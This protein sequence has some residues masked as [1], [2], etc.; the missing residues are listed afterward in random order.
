VKIVSRKECG[1][2]AWDGVVMSSPDGWVW[3]LWKWQE[4]ILAVPRWQLAE[5][6]FAVTDGSRPLAVVPLQWSGDRRV[7]GCSGWGFTAPAL[8][9]DLSGSERR[10]TLDV[11]FAEMDRIARRGSAT[12]IDL[13]LS[14]VSATAMAVRDQNP[15]I[16]FG[17]AGTTGQ[18]RALDLS[19]SEDE[20]LADCSRDTRQQLRKARDR[21][22]TSRAVAWPE[23]LDD[24]YRLHTETYERT[25][26]Q[27]HPRE[28]FSGIAHA[29]GHDGHSVLSA[30]FDRDGRVL[31]FHNTARLA[32]GA[33][34]HTGCSTA[35]ALDCGAN[36]VA[37]WSAVLGAKAAGVRWYE[38]GEV[39]PSVSSG[40]QRGLTTFKSKFGGQ[41]LSI[42]RATRAIEP[43]PAAT[44]PIG[45]LL[46]WRSRH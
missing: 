30:A 21:G 46:R 4:L 39:F 14:P 15:F 27:P 20:L 36:Y 42:H 32:G 33:M 41:S 2:E 17:Y 24:Y 12:R 3:A 44:G 25:G 28:Y 19:Q 5:A 9:A 7:L 11:V 8:A 45:R 6:S 34:Y 40:K 38:I 22:V 1:R 10:A 16:E 18:V 35:A 43:E 26:E 13:A 37:L 23:F 29:L 31:A